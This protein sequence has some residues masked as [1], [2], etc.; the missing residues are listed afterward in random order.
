MSGSSRRATSQGCRYQSSASATTS[1]PI[2]CSPSDG[3][4][5]SRCG[6]RDRLVRACDRRFGAKPRGLRDDDA[7]AIR[8]CCRGGRE[9]GDRRATG[10][11]DHGPG[12]A[13]IRVWTPP[14]MQ[15][16]FERLGT[17]GQVLSCVRPLDCGGLPATGPVWRYAD[18]VHIGS[19]SLNALRDQPGFPDPVSSTVCP[20]PSSVL[21]TSPTAPA[22][23]CPFRCQSAFNTDPRSACKIDPPEWHG[24]GCPGSQ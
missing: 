5:A 22:C 16:F 24:G 20:Y 1:T 8:G 23:R 9:P 4:I 13:M 19:A 2:R 18:R 17:C 12:A 7:S 11:C 10:T 14:L 15:A 3:S 6:C 21:P